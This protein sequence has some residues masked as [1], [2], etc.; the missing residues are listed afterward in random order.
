MQEVDG[1][2]WYSEQPWVPPELTATAESTSEPPSEGERCIVLVASKDRR[3]YRG[4]ENLAV[5]D[6]SQGWNNTGLRVSVRRGA[7]GPRG[8]EGQDGNRVTDVTGDTPRRRQAWRLNT[9]GSHDAR[10]AL[11]VT[12]LHNRFCEL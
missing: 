9:A 2:W 12:S 11:C 8:T 4:K 5:P 3:H 7:H 6:N 1:S 10:A